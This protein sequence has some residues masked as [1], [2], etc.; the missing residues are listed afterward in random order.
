MLLLPVD[1]L[2]ALVLASLRR[3]D[4]AAAGVVP[5]PGDA[6]IVGV[7]HN[8]SIACLSTLDMD[9]ILEEYRHDLSPKGAR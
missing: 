6:V 4:P 3:R 7:P 2:V 9:A 8:S 5:Q 1:E